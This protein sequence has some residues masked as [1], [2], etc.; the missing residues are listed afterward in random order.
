MTIKMNLIEEEYTRVINEKIKKIDF[1]YS[2]CEDIVYIEC[3][4]TLITLGG[5][6]FKEIKELV[7]MN[8]KGKEFS[9]EKVEKFWNEVFG[10]EIGSIKWKKYKNDEN[11][12]VTIN[13]KE[14][15]VDSDWY[16]EYDEN[17]ESDGESVNESDEE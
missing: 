9:N 2:R 5:V 12:Y 10:E 11:K 13:E 1:E 6:H 16:V 17:E 14:F 3:E 7:K 8:G 15:V 4:N